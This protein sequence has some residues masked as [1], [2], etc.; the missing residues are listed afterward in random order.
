MIRRFRFSVSGALAGVAALLVFLLSL[1]PT[2]DSGRLQAHNPSHSNSHAA[3]CATL[4][5]D[6]TQTSLR[7]DCAVL[8]DI[9]DTLSGTDAGSPPNWDAGVVFASWTGITTSGTGADAR[10]TRISLPSK[11]LNGEIPTEIGSLTGLTG[12]I[13]YNNPGLTGKIPAE[14]GNLRNLT[15]LRLYSTPGTGQLSGSIPKELGNLTSL[16]TLRLNGNQLS[17]AIPTQ[18]G[19]L[20]SLET[21][22]LEENQLSGAI[23]AQLGNLTSLTRLHLGRNPLTPGPMPTWIYGLTNLQHLRMN[24]VGLTSVSSSLTNLGSLSTLW[25]Q[26][27]KLTGAI[28]SWLGT[29]TSLRDL[30]LSHNGFTG[31][32]PQE[33]TALTDL[34][35]LFLEDNQLT[36]GIPDVSGMT[37]LEVL[38]LSGNRLS[39]AIPVGLAIAGS[40]PN[41][42]GIAINPL[43]QP[44]DRRN[45]Q[46]VG[47]L[48]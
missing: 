11:G 34:W 46:P 18:L 5:T 19:K 48:D 44:I 32:I 1:F 28:P 10:V 27:N 36:G 21:L 26:E 31:P 22:R 2:S 13:L 23:P 45:T 40:D 30:D 14:L 7:S 12:L 33:F 6:S 8:L 20:R 37:E 4:I 41:A 47:E 38:N 3:I 24:D 35:A 16:E 9:K 42:F 25:L 43:Q 39:G 29:M 17:G 15:D